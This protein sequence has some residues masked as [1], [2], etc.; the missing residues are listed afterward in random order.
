MVGQQ[1]NR[2]SGGAAVSKAVAGTVSVDLLS[3]RIDLIR[4]FL[5]RFA[6]HLEGFRA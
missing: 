2:V 1:G 5:P 4:A 3:A 6:K